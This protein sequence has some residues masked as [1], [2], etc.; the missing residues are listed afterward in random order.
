MI[1]DISSLLAKGEWKGNGEFCIR[2]PFCGDS[3]SHSHLYINIEN[4]WFHCFYC[5]K[6]GPASCL[7]IKMGDLPEFTYTTP[8]VHPFNLDEFSKVVPGTL[9][10]SY[11]TMRGVTD[12]EILSRNM[13]FSLSG[14]YYGR[15]IVPIKEANRV[16][17]M[18]ARSFL[19][20][21]EPKYLFPST[22]ETLLT[23]SN[24][25]F[26][27]DLLVKASSVIIVEGVF[28]ALAVMR[29]TKLPAVALMGKQLKEGQKN[30]LH[31]IDVERY[32]VML[33]ADAF[34][35]NVTVSRTL[36]AYLPNRVYVCELKRGDP[37]VASE[38]ELVEVLRRS[39]P[40]SMEVEVM[41]R[42]HE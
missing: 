15:V 38:T 33:D 30:K 3:P 16:V 1:A 24:S 13:R 27:Y 12:E 40:F 7:G 23:S 6:G 8:V 20:V 18:V 19:P 28:D 36:A 41:S 21:I 17:C 32:Y 5:G 10:Y 11:L 26:G 9:A 31:Q 34:S 14:K 37:D 4:N 29:K 25:L 2:C 35:E 42:F 39:V 22:G